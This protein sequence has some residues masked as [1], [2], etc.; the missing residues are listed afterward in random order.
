MKAITY[1]RYG[2]PEVLELS[3]V[4]KPKF[5]QNSIV[6]RVKA[7]GI[8]PVD[9]MLQEGAGESL[10]DA[11]FPVIPGWDVAGV[12]EDVG[13]GVSE[14]QRGD[15]V[16]GYFRD[17]ILRHGTYAELVAGPVEAFARKPRRLSW[18]EAA[19]LPLPGLTAYRAIV[20]ALNVR[21]NETLLVHGA[22][23]AIG[24]LAAQIA[25]SRGAHVIGSGAETNHAFLKSL[26]VEPV[27][28]G[29]GL[30]H[31]VREL[32]PEG[33]NAVM[34]CGGHGALATTPEVGNAQVRACSI[35]ESVSGYPMVF[36]R[37]E[38]LDLVALCDLADAGR[39][40]VRVS[41][42]FPLEQAADAQRVLRE[43]RANGKV[44]LEI[45]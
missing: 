42:S 27:A 18:A 40:V 33:V 23:G 12:V 45:T 39:L 44:V 6:V 17:E 24:S 4:P 14:F 7:A 26:G 9:Y 16:I 3:E 41:Q 35:V 32:A 29:E 36:V 10:M 2:G 28:Y 37:R 13:P 25:L 11:W 22:S 34:D 19:G 30:V 1:D 8:N 21:E 43:G 38:Q 31:R 5:A 20:R 15:E